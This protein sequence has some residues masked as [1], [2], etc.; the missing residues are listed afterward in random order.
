MGRW[1]VFYC[2]VFRNLKHSLYQFFIH[3]ELGRLAA[4]L[5]IAFTLTLF[6]ADG[7]ATAEKLFQSPASPVSQPPPAQQQPPTQQQQP[8][9]QSSNEAP[10]APPPEQSSTEPTPES[11]DSTTES[12]SPAPEPLPEGSGPPPFVQP[13]VEIGGDNFEAE[14][15]FLDEE[16]SSSNFILDRVELVDSIV[17]S[18]AYVWFCCGVFL[19]LL[20]PLIFLFLQIRGQIKI[21]QEED[22]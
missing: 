22:F 3:F 17:V 8:S 19:L 2:T 7:S 15:E 10:E 20:I 5:V 18:G 1:A 16:A 12:Q 13:T 6:I 4:L 9:E 21:R 11:S 14:D